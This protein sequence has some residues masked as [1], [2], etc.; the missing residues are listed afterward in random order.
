MDWP[1]RTWRVLVVSTDKSSLYDPC[2]IGPQVMTVNGKGGMAG[3]DSWQ[4]D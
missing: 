1:D 4:G 2:E 3:L